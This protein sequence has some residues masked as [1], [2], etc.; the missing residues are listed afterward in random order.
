MMNWKGFGKK[1]LQP[2]AGIILEGLRKTMKNLSSQ[3]SNS[4]PPE[5][6]FKMLQQ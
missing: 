6:E 5:Y 1:Q 4:A 3:N 2:N